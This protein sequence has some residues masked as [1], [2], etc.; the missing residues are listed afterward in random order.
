MLPAMPDG[1]AAMR[2][3]RQPGH[4]SAAQL[5][6]Q[7]Y[8]QM[9]RLEEGR[10]GADMGLALAL[11]RAWMATGSRAESAGGFEWLKKVSP[12]CVEMIEASVSANAPA[13]RSA[14]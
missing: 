12:I 7:I 13:F 2:T 4:A 14:E 10:P 5:K 11:L 9:F 6:D 3:H 1:K 8:R